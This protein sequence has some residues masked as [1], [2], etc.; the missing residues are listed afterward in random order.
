MIDQDQN[1]RKLQSTLFESK[2][3]STQLAG[4]RLHEINFQNLVE[5]LTSVLSSL[6]F[7]P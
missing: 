7:K 6:Y 3:S 2:Q 4:N 5:V 1:L